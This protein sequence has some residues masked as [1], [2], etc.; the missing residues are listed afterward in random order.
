MGPVDVTN[1]WGVAVVFVFIMASFTAIN[2]QQ[3]IGEWCKEKCQENNA[4]Y[5]SHKGYGIRE[6]E[7]QCWCKNNETIPFR[8]G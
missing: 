2:Q 1:I 8:V 4:T 3:H 6:P 5:V 7:S